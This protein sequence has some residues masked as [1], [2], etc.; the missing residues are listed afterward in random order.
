MKIRSLLTVLLAGLIWYGAFYLFF[1]LSGAQNIL[2]NPAHQSDKFL[3][4]FMEIEPLP[5]VVSDSWLV[6][7][8]L[9]VIGFIRYIFIIVW[10]SNK[11]FYIKPHAKLMKKFGIAREK[12]SISDSTGKLFLY[13]LI[14][15]N[16]AHPLPKALFEIGI[17]LS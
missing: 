13:R 14:S 3:R 15:Q 7:K 10:Y 1:I 11:W 6:I 4:V 12:E 16:H 17:W 2:A 9:F 5:R 8:G